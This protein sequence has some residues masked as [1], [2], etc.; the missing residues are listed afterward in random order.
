MLYCLIDSNGIFNTPVI[1]VNWG[2]PYTSG[3]NGT[4][5]AFTKIYVEIRITGTSIMHSQKF[6]FKNR[7]ITYKCF[8]M[9]AHHANN[10]QSSLLTLHIRLLLAFIT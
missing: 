6:I 5:V 8:Q 4:N 7:V 1:C 9:C 3:K 10:Y 2:K